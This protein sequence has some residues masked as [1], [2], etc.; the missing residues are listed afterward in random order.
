MKT[1]ATKRRVQRG[2]KLLDSVTPD[3]F[4]RI[5]ISKLKMD[6]AFKKDDGCGC[7]MAQLHETYSDGLIETGITYAARG[8]EDCA[9]FTTA[10][11]FGLDINA[12]GWDLDERDA[13]YRALERDWKDEIRK[14]RAA[15]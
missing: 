3:W 5:K 10:R 6:E 13:E 8:M 14:R 15:A 2:A 1:P 12:S 9:D 4:K 11:D 7:V